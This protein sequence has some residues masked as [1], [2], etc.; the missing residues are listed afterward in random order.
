[1]DLRLGGCSLLRGFIEKRRTCQSVGSFYPLLAGCSWWANKILATSAL[2]VDP[3]GNFIHSGH[4]EF[5]SHI[6]LCPSGSVACE[7]VC[8]SGASQADDM[9]ASVLMTDTELDG[10]S[11]SFAYWKALTSM[12]ATGLTKAPWKHRW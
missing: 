7:C 1:M 3:M 12:R 9:E 10:M 6:L 4:P 11:P 2:R 8:I 5:G